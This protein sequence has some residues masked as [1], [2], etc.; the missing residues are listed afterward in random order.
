ME[1]FAIHALPVGDGLLALC[2]MP[3]RGGAYDADLQRLAA[4]SPAA[5]LTLTGPEE[6]ARGGAARLGADLAARGIDWLHLPIL[7]YGVPGAAAADRW[8]AIE[9]DLGSRLAAGGRV[10]IHCKGGCGRSGMIA[11]RLMIALGEPAGRAL[12]RL[13][14]LRPCAVETPEQEAWARA[15]PA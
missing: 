11:L 1:A 9:A 7:D 3:G 12:S 5:V 8:P 6:L 15:R 14:A 10:L 13:R 2:P 4:W